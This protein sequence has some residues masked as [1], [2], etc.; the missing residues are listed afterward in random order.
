[1]TYDD[2]MIAY[3]IGNDTAAQV[4]GNLAELS[5]DKDDRHGFDDR[6]FPEA[7]DAALDALPMEDAPDVSEPVHEGILAYW[8]AA[9]LSEYSR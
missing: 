8:R 6:V 3:R 4:W 2:Y 7:F 1:M 9:Q 5:P